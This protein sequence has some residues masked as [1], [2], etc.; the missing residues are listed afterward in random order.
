MFST[1]DIAYFEAIA[2][3]PESKVEDTVFVEDASFSSEERTHEDRNAEQTSIMQIIIIMNL[4]LLCFFM[5]F[6]LFFTY[7]L[8]CSINQL[9][10]FSKFEVSLSFKGFKFIVEK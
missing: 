1:S 8:M 6:L 4:L 7:F 2:V 10:K 5:F 9:N 3:S